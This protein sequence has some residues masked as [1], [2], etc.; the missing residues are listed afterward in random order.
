MRAL[1]GCILLLWSGLAVAWEVRGEVGLEGRYFPH[2]G[3]EVKWHGNGSAYARAEVLHD[4]NR[5]RDLFT[6]IP[7]ARVDEH[8]ERRTHGDIR[9]LSWIHVGNGWESRVGIRKVFWGVTE[10][11]NLV[12]IINQTDQV[13]QVDGEEKLGQPMINLSWAPRWGTLDFFV[14]PGFRERTYPGEDGRPRFPIVVAEDEAAYESPA[15]N[16]RVDFAARGQFFIGDLELAVSHFS[17]TSREPRLV[18]NA[19]RVP[20]QTIGPDFDHKLI[21]VYDV[22]DQTGLEMLMARG[23]WLWKLEAMSRS[24]QGERFEAATGGFEYAQSG[25]FGTS[26]DL[27]WILEYLW[28]EDRSNLAKS[29][30]EHDWLIGQRF[31]FNDAAGTEVLWTLIQDQHSEEKV[32]NLEASRRLGGDFK[33]TLEGRAY[34]DTGDPLTRA[35][36]VQLGRQGRDIFDGERLTPF[37]NDDFVQAELI[38]YF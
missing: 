9:E 36:V 38:W 15:E 29:P 4:W 11:R 22:I 20:P 30:F 33:L 8:D 19:L 23:S 3:P 1:A 6:F 37:A 27:D 25:L 12:D 10:G 26:V 16:E 34:T 32:I 14:L 13:D 17:G 18:P 2:E 35:E 28:E 5:G 7:Y 21:P 24:G 31:S